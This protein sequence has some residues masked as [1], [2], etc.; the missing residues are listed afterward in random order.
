MEYVVW[1]ALDKEPVGSVGEGGRRQLGHHHSASNVGRDHNTDL[2]GDGE[3]TPL[4]QTSLALRHG[5]KSPPRRMDMGRAEE[6]SRTRPVP[7]HQLHPLQLGE[8]PEERSHWGS[9]GD[10]R[11]TGTNVPVLFVIGYNS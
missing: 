7:A 5:P 11:L 8:G 6:K 2:G 10:I 9:V 1:G 4:Q 3:H